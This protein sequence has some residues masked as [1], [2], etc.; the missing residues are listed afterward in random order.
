MLTNAKIMFGIIE[1]PNRS[2][3]VAIKVC[4]P[5]EVPSTSLI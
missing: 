5:L 3:D 1:Y 4:A 2:A